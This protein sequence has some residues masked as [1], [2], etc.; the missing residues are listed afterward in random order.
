MRWKYA[1]LLMNV[2]NAAEALAGPSARGSRIAGLARQ[3]ALAALAAAGIAFVSDEDFARRRGDLIRPQSI[4]DGPRPGGSSWQSL[5]R[6]TGYIEADYLNGEISLLGREHGVST[7][8][9]DALRLAANRAARLG[10]RPGSPA[11]EELLDA[12]PA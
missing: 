7:P 11:A 5:E 6:G 12:L 3:E 10:M 1:K 9:N 4:G 8:A 2:G